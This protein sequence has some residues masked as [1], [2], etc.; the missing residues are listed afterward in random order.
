MKD[1]IKQFTNKH[2]D[3]EI[4][5]EYVAFDNLDVYFD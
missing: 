4:Y 2:H 1:I 5:I 3:I